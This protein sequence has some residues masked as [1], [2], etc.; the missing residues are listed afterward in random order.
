MHHVA[1]HGHKPI[2][3]RKMLILMTARCRAA[4]TGQQTN[5]VAKPLETAF[6]RSETR[7]VE[8]L[9]CCLTS[10]T[11]LYQRAAVRVFSET[12]CAMRARISASSIS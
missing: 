3:T 2:A 8:L 4:Q 12:I 10:T 6:F 11:R 1:R 9:G 5:L 7:D